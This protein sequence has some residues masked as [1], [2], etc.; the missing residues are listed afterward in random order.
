MPSPGKRW[1]H[2]TI[3]THNSWLPGDPR[4]FRSRNHKIHSSGDHKNPPP[5]GEHA[6]LHVFRRATSGEAVLLSKQARAI[7][8]QKIVETLSN[9]KHRVL[10]VSVGGMHVHLLSELPSD[11]EEARHE[12]GIA[13]KS[14]SQAINH[15]PTGRIWAK[16]CG[17]KPIRDEEH[18][19]NTFGYI[20]RHAEK[21]AFIWSF[22][23]DD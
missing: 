1:F 19:R 6:G 4:G 8:A 22:R 21:G 7:V 3:G 2:V 10:I 18:Q 16:G 5:R 17:L 20:Q 14:A 23:D 12:I 15:L 9:R 13:K 11:R